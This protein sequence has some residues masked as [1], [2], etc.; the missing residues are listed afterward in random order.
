MAATP[1]RANLCHAIRYL[2]FTVI[3]KPHE[4]ACINCIQISFLINSETIAPTQTIINIVQEMFKITLIDPSDIT[5][6]VYYEFVLF[7]IFSCEKPDD[8]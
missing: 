2:P 4:I 7:D 5:P 1:Y 6:I 8:V 3:C